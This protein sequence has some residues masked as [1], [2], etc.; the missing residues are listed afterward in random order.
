MPHHLPTCR[1]ISSPV[2]VLSSRP[3]RFR[4]FCSE[5]TL[6]SKPPR[7]P[8]SGDC[9]SV[10]P[11][12]LVSFFALTCLA[13]PPSIP[14]AGFHAPLR[15]DSN[16]SLPPPEPLG[17]PTAGAVVYHGHHPLLSFRTS[18]VVGSLLERRLSSRPAGFA[19]GS[20]FLLG[21]V[22]F[23]RNCHFHF[24]SASDATLQPGGGMPHARQ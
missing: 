15:L 22:R 3:V 13:A 2:A 18:I 12:V 4:F 8:P 20:L 5:F 19:V 24:Y 14:P 1:R 23:V 21:P 9:S 17:P 7:S 11:D 6:R 10:Q 16:H